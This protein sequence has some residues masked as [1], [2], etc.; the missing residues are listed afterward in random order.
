MIYWPH[1][2]ARLYDAA[3][4]ASGRHRIKWHDHIKYIISCLSHD[5]NIRQ[6]NI[7]TGLPLKG[8]NTIYRCTTAYTTATQAQRTD[9]SN[10]HR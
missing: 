4:C 2:S 9:T 7:G 8:F 5:A 3:V 1:A 10:I 6:L